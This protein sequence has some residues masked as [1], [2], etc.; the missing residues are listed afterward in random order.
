MAMLTEAHPR[1][2]RPHVAFDNL[3]VGEATKSNTPSYTVNVRH[4]G[5]HPKRRSRTFMVGVDEH[6]YSNDAL[7]WLLDEFVD[8]GDEVICVRVVE[9]DVRAVGAKDYQDEANAMIAKIQ[10]KSGNSRAISIVLEYAVG[11]LH[12]TFQRLVCGCSMA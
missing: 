5:Y 12:S 11:K 4:D 9:K 8:D 1:R 10:E 3:V 6:P 7:Q 2:F